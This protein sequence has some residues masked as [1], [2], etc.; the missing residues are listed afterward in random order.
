MSTEAVEYRP[1]RAPLVPPGRMD[2]QARDMTATFSA[3]VT[4]A[5]AQRK[6]AEIGQ[7]LAV[8][9]DGSWTLGRLVETNSTGPLRLGYGAWRDLLLGSQFLNGRGQLITAGGRTVKN[10]AGYDLTKF[11]VGQAGVF[12]RSVTITTRT[13]A[14]PAG[15]MAARF[16]SDAW[17]VNRLLPTPCRP[18]WAVM[19]R[20]A[21]WCGY[22]GDERT[23]AYYRGAVA[24]HGPVEVVERTVEEDE[25]HRGELWRAAAMDGSFRASVPPVKLLEF[26]RNA[27]LTDWAADAAFGIVVGITQTSNHEAIR[28]AARSVGGS[29]YFV[30]AG[31]THADLDEAGC[32]GLRR[33]KMAIRPAGKLQ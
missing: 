18:Q 3:D 5:E 31:R 25:R 9:G 30:E 4:L 1:D 21:L 22:L 29:V 26:S 13:Y 6:L 33:L 8:D 16:P 17:Q 7:W 11:M 32:A 10:V 19:T 27:R 2:L 24:E 20:D 12:G 28:A 14:R 15:A 23:I